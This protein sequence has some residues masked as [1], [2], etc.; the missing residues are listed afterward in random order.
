MNVATVV[1]FEL[2]KILGSIFLRLEK[3]FLLAQFFLLARL[4]VFK[5]VKV[6]FSTVLCLSTLTLTN[7]RS[8]VAPEKSF[9][10]ARIE[11]STSLPLVDPAN[12]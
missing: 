10:L 9:E 4:F 7:F 8:A 5:L 2:V 11:L 6:L 3:K 12:H 1:D